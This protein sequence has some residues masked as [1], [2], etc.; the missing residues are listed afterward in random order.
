M[1][2]IECVAEVGDIL[3]EGPIW[4]VAEQALYWVDAYGQAIRR[5]TPED[6]SVDSW[7]MPELI[8]SLV[9]REPGGIIAGMKS[10]FRFVDLDSNIFETIADP[11]PGSNILLNDGKCDRRGRYWCGTIDM[12]L[13][14]P[15]GK[16]WRLDP[17]LT[18]HCM[19]TGI[20]VSNG[21]AWSPDDTIMYFADTRADTVYAYDFD[22]E[23]GAI[24]NRRV[25]LSTGD[26]PG[27]VDGATVDTEGYYW[28]AL[29]HDGHIARYAPDGRLDRRID[30]PV[31][32]PT[33]CTFGGAGFEDLYVTSATRFLTAETKAEQPQAG[34][35][36]VIRDLGVRG[37]PEPLF[38]G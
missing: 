20:T 32:H 6:G 4:N 25:F 35:L 29:I 37:L 8:G 13:S 2:D 34:A 16:L 36:F 15:D 21:I 10:G 5:Y 9:F 7:K 1:V 27:R 30:L 33:M 26:M 38:A 19:D 3:G 14:R 22:I 23:T 18:C 12:S 24:A 31:R 28:C 11:Q 17:D